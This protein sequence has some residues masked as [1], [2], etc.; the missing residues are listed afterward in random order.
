METKDSMTDKCEM[1]HAKE[2]QVRPP[3]H[4][5]ERTDVAPSQ[6]ASEETS[7]TSQRLPHPRCRQ[8]QP[9]SRT[10]PQSQTVA[11]L[12][13]QVPSGPC[14]RSCPCVCSRLWP[15]CRYSATAPE[16]SSTGRPACRPSTASELCPIVAPTNPTG[17]DA[18]RQ[19]LVM[20]VPRA[21]SCAYRLH[22][23]HGRN[24]GRSR[25]RSDSHGRSHGC[26]RNRRWPTPPASAPASVPAPGPA[27]CSSYCGILHPMTRR[28]PQNSDGAPVLQLLRRVTPRR[29]QTP[30]SLGS[31]GLACSCLA[32]VGFAPC[33][34]A[35][36]PRGT[37]IQ[38]AWARSCLQSQP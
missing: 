13:S 6:S 25:S 30:R 2:P 11:R 19:P 16:E 24:R 12:Q 17:A 18:A 32:T 8:S 10:R 1:R 35:D 20:P 29:L 33:L 3:P 15:G 28:L 31:P 38:R 7:R 37:P 34:W 5:H 27:L 9:R 36:E 21:A 14:H 26:G 4:R 23:G 22:S